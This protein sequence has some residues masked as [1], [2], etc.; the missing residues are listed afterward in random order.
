[1]DAIRDL[2]WHEGRFLG[3]EW[4]AWKMV[5]WL[6]NA[7][8]TSRILVQWYASEKLRRVVVPPLYWWL[9][10]SGALLLLAY[11]AL[12]RKDSVFIAAHAVS[13]IPYLRNLILHRRTEKARPVCRNC[14]SQGHE[15]DAFCARCGTAH[16]SPA[17]TLPAQ[18]V[19]S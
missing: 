1:M 18:S 15:G 16:G 10:L 5:G 14:S 8:F 4:N 11:A 2:L 6:G 19:H 3:I 7:V 9:S 13:W 17:G 12:Y